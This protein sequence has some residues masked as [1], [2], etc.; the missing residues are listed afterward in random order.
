MTGVSDLLTPEQVAERLGLHV[1]TVRR[2]IR[3]GQLEAVRVG[4]RYRVTRDALA[5]FT[6]VPPDA[7]GR[8]SG[9]V[10]EVSTIVFI[11]DV[12]HDTADR[13]TTLLTASAQGRG[14][15]DDSL[16]LETLYYPERERLKIV[17][18][19]HLAVTLSLLALVNTLLEENP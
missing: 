15:T 19:G 18:S 3:E 11:D 4:K 13:L 2:Y 5:S 9:P 6:G 10:T 8:P 14:A 17:I 1:K 16:R 7:E 12:G